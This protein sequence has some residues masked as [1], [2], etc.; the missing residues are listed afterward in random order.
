MGTTQ[1][2]RWLF[3]ARIALGGLFTLLGLVKLLAGPARWIKLG[4]AMT[5]LGVDA[6]PLAWGLAAACAEL[7]CGLMLV[8]G[9]AFRPAS[10]V[11]VWVMVVAATMHA[12][13]GS[14]I[15]L[16]LAPI[17]TGLALAGLLVAGPGTIAFRAAWTNSK[18]ERVLG[19]LRGE[20]K[21]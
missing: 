10:A 14:H 13:K 8:T 17:A 11:L 6:F 19:A 16:R 7:A 21:S 15:L 2:D 20:K 4:G 3:R 12:Q 1:I 18:L 9:R 5:Y